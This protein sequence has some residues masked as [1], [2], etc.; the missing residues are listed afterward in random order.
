[1]IKKP[2]TSKELMSLKSKIMKAFQPDLRKVKW[3][4]KLDKE[5]TSLVL[6]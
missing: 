4:A 6:K 3:F 2:L 5:K 1:M